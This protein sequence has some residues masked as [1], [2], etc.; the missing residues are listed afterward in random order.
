MKKFLVYFYFYGF[1][2]LENILSSLSI[3]IDTMSMN[4]SLFHTN[5]K[6]LLLIYVNEE[7]SWVEWYSNYRSWE[8]FTAFILISDEKLSDHIITISSLL[9]KI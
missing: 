6:S 8:E 7:F 9:E 2:V 1:T 5:M 3:Q 4:H